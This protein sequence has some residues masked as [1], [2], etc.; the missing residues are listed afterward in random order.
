MKYLQ[1]TY[2]VIAIV[3][4]A[5]LGK[6]FGQGTNKPF[7][8]LGGKPLIIWSL[9]ALEAVEE[10]CEI[11]PVLKPEDMEFGQ[12]LLEEEGFQK[13]KRIAAGGKERQDSVYNG[14]KHIED[15]N[16]IVLIHDGVRPFIRTPLVKELIR[17]MS[18]AIRNKE[19][20]DGII[21]GVPVKDTIK[22]TG[23]GLV[24]KTLKRG[25]LWAVQ[26]PQAFPYKKILKAYEEAARKGYYATDDAAL[27]ERYG[28]TVKV[29]MGAYTNIKITTPEDLYI[30]EAL[31]NM[32]VQS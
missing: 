24:K 23:D 17:Q 14:L 3:P 26:T 2:K 7:Q 30:A 20:C 28:G 10:V 21:P 32:N 1:T 18:D 11:I 16:S 5:G 6:R 9:K 27:I 8:T 4:A 31:L 25:S 29:I 13:I 15:N 19:E 22:E 12:R